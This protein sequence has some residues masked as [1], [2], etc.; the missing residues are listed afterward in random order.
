M[1][2]TQIAKGRDINRAPK[3]K[4]EKCWFLFKYEELVALQHFSLRWERD[5][6]ESLLVVSSLLE[7][8]LE[9][10]SLL[11]SKLDGR[12]LPARYLLIERH[13]YD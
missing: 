8:K 11:S 5:C 9:I 2:R 13:F 10:S 4:T 3:A 7:S 12:G 6:L 1:S